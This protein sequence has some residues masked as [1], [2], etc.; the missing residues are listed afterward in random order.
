MNRQ[1]VIIL[2][3]KYINEEIPELEKMFGSDSDKDTA[4]YYEGM[5]S[6]LKIVRNELSQ[7]ERDI[8][9]KFIDKQLKALKNKDNWFSNSGA[10]D[11]FLKAKGLIGMIDRPNN[12]LRQN[13]K[14][15][16]REIEIDGKKYTPKNPLYFKDLIG[17]Q[18]WILNNSVYGSYG[19]NPSFKDFFE[20]PLK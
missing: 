14:I 13:N 8:V 3:D 6:A 19:Y 20:K 16:F 2:I 17:N 12:K 4:N 1:E 11:G 10:I 9:M 7:Y 5:S 15:P 18:L